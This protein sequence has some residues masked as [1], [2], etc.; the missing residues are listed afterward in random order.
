MNHVSLH[1]DVQDGFGGLYLFGSL[2]DFVAGNADQVRQVFGN[3]TV[4]FSV[5]NF[6]GFVQDHWSITR[7]LTLDLGV[8]YDFEHLPSIFNQG[9][10]NFSPRVGLAW[11]HPSGSYAP[12]MAFFLTGMFSPT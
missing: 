1:A 12:D 9:I 7:R 6:G 10:N 11:S 4:N 5:T 8:R 3:P 2:A